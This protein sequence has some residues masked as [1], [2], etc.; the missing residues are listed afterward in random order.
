MTI[1]Q[2][3]KIV[4]K[5]GSSLLTDSSKGVVRATWLKTLVEDTLALTKQGKRIV[6][7]TSGSVALGKHYIEH[8]K[9]P[10]KLEEKQAAAACGQIEL[11][12]MYQKYFH[13]HKK[14][15]AQVLLTVQDSDYRRHYLNAKNTIETL[16]D[17]NIIPI[18]NE[19]DTVAT[20]ELRF[21][22]NDRLA[23]R[24][25]QMIEADL[26]LILSDVDGLYDSNPQINEKA[27]HITKVTAITPDIQQMAGGSVSTVGSGGMV[28]KI[29]AARIATSNGCSVIISKGALKHPIRKLQHGGKHTLFESSETPL[30]A[31]KRWFYNNLNITGEIILDAGAAK[32]LLNG[33]SLLPAGV[34][35]IKGVF[36]RG[37]AVLILTPDY[38]E[39]GRGLVAYS[40]AET[41]LIM[42]RK[43]ADIESILG[44]AGRDE[45][46]HR[47][48]MA[49]NTGGQA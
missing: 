14:Q 20:Q 48:N 43:S 2:A 26:L 44:F 49:I 42:G 23:A 45:L 10:L 13:K 21:G 9:A 8:G 19:N 28:T 17:N 46:I 32:A 29:E 7:V 18:I 35:A 31:R 36:E 25:A 24:V 47:N 34:T 22:D 11:M 30:T 41:K 38:L 33:K 40:S 6:I 15:V 5:I 12:R 39:I 3:N 37:D 27:K 1:Q 16:L 4:I